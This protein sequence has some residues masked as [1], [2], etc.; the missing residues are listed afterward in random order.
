MA[1][2]N[3]FLLGSGEKLTAPVKIEPGGS[4]K[5]PPYDFAHARD[6]IVVRLGTV[7]RQLR[8]LPAEACPEDRAVALVTMH[9]R[10]ISKSDYPF[11]LLDTV[12]LQPIGSRS[13]EVKPEAWGTK[14]G[15]GSAV[16]EQ[17]FVEGRRE[18]FS[19]WEAQVGSWSPASRE[20][21]DLTHIEDVA[22]VT[23]NEKLRSIPERS[24][25]VVLE[26]ALHNAGDPRLF[27]S[28]AEYV[29]KIGGKV[30]RDRRRD[31]R[32]LTFVP[33]EARAEDAA[34]VA[35][36]AFVR[37]VRGMPT[38]RPFRPGIVRSAAASFPMKLPTQDAVDQSR[39][40]LVL[41]GGLPGVVDISRWV[42]LIDPPGIGAPD[43]L[44]QEHGL[45]V[46]SALLFGQLEADVQAERPLCGVDHVR[47]LD[48]RT[49]RA[50]DYLYS[51]VLARIMSTLA[52]APGKYEFVNISI[53]PN[54]AVNDDEVTA[55]TA[56]LDEFFSEHPAVV[57]VAAGNDGD[58]DPASGNNRVQPPG[59][60]V[61]V[62]TVGACT[63]L[64][65]PWARA[66]YSSMGPGRSPGVVKPDGI[67]FGGCDAEPFMVLAPTPEPRARGLSGTSFASPLALRATV[68][69]GIQFGAHVGPL[70]L[71]AL[72]IHRADPEDHSRAE[73]GWGRFEYRAERLV[74][75]DDD[76]VIVIYQGVLPLSQHLRAAIPVAPGMKGL[77]EISA[78]LLLAPAVDPEHPGAY[79]RAGFEVAFRPTMG[80]LRRNKDGTLSK[81]PKTKTMFGE[82]TYLAEYQLRGDA[83]K[84]EPCRR[85]T[86]KCRASSLKNPVLDVYYHHRMAG[87]PAVNPRPLPYALV[88][89]VRAPSIP[90]LYARTVAAY[91]QVLVPLQPQLRIP[92]R[93]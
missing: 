90:D 27:E 80:K 12:G 93:T 19:A 29:K 57:A 22:A 74:T 35:A 71:R 59:D 44:F 52:E 48:S 78:T 26:V 38:I 3:N 67:V 49:G 41:D 76:E 58:L 73:V 11:G 88:V 13:R 43:P 25:V 55:W 54:L 21:T 30:V 32:G 34:A 23:P 82:K 20:G 14:S 61:N 51:D 17:I 6:R 86:T 64:G 5:S 92:I 68:G 50:A 33:V 56:S 8:R 66:T 28:F 84:W 75:C 72:M 69:G 63:S 42:N 81:Q 31:V 2:E 45:A 1:R 60:G 85:E 15:A 70:A 39:R 65:S 4:P 62:M 83:H 40:V 79:T 36:F 77:V 37:V 18:A 53:G 7:N 91:Q 89:G 9:P 46:T 87:S 47:V 16:T 10:Y 24:G